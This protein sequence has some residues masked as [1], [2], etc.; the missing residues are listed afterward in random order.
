MFQ[1]S[2]KLP[3]HIP[4]TIPFLGHAV[5]FGQNPI[6]FLLAAYQK[7]TSLLN[8]TNF[9]EFE[10]K[11]KLILPKDLVYFVLC[12]IF[13]PHTLRGVKLLNYCPF[14]ILPHVRVSLKNVVHITFVMSKWHWFV[15][16]MVQYSASLWL[17][18]PSRTWSGQMQQRLSSTAR[19]R[20]WTLRRC[21]GNSL[22]PCLEKESLMTC[23]IMYVSSCV[24][25][26][27]PILQC[28]KSC[29][30]LQL[31]TVHRNL[32]TYMNIKFI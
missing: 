28:A 29:M 5:S 16:S 21:M 32:K 22:R 26:S 9:E 10:F 3:P 20:I 1:V 4:S 2:T 25:M 19:M 11:I 18:R 27:V 6:E 30:Y 7:V 12:S 14:V 24:L 17:V 23:L 13:M 8:I 15:F 31:S